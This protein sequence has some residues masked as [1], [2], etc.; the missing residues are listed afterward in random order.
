MI[1]GN[2][3]RFS[4]ATDS[5]LAPGPRDRALAQPTCLPLGA[6]RWDHG[7]VKAW[8]VQWLAP[9]VVFPN[10]VS[11]RLRH[12][13][14]I[15]HYN[16]VIMGAMPSQITSLTIVYSAVYSGADQRKY[17]SSA[18]LASLC[19]EFTGTGEFP[20]QMASNAENVSIWW[21]R[22]DPAFLWDLIIV[23]ISIAFSYL[24]LKG[25]KINLRTTHFPVSLP[26]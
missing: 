14:V 2:F 25:T 15:T 23:L 18:S 19:G 20:A 17:Q 21:R 5:S 8:L 3:H 12:G 1:G 4:E 6:V 22:H 13:Q 26:V 16:D 10:L 9:G 7:R 11:L 24:S